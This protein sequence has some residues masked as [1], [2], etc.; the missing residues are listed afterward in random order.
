MTDVI[1]VNRL[2]ILVW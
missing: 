1:L 2:R